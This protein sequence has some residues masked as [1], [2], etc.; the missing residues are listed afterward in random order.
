[1]GRGKCVLLALLMIALHNAVASEA[2]N[3][4][5]VLLQFSVDGAALKPVVGWPA[6][7]R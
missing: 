4:E 7:F 2:A 3:H 5:R 6:V 1:M